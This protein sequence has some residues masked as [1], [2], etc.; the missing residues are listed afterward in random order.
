[1]TENEGFGTRTASLL[2]KVKATGLIWFDATDFSDTVA[3]ER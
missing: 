1:M 2:T 3:V